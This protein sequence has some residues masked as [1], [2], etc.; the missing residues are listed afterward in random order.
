MKRNLTRIVIMVVSIISLLC[1]LCYAD[2]IDDSMFLYSRPSTPVQQPET[3]NVV[4]MIIIGI[5][6]VVI[7]VAAIIVLVKSKKN[8]NKE[9]N[10][11]K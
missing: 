5:V 11:E 3:V 7:V 1:G 9:V 10:N 6:I 8:K 2:L 4:P